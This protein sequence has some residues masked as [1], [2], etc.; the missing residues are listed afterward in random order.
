[1][2]VSGSGKTLIARRLAAARSAAFADADDFHP[3]EN[4]AKMA[5]GLPLDD[6]DR[7]PWLASLRRW[8]GER[9][10]EGRAA[11]LACSALKRRYRDA[12]RAGLPSVAFV[13]LVVPAEE[14]ARRLE[15]RTHFM[16]R[17]LLASQLET[18]EPLE[19]DER[20]IDVDGTASP[21]AIVAE[22]LLAF[23]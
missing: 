12:L 6:D 22:I 19:P 4:V 1:M 18:L 20:G 23:A 21:E 15:S 2:G 7:A 16:P 13:H 9:H 10:A 5:S 17:A 3:P 8:L 11:V 14:L